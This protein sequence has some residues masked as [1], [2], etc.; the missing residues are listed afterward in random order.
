MH[1]ARVVRTPSGLAGRVKSHDVC[2]NASSRLID[3]LA[4][5]NAVSTSL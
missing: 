3:Q 4:M 1:D 2:N 5:S